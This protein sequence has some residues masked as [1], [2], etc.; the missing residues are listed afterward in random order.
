MRQMIRY[1]KLTL[2]F[3]L[4]LFTITLQ[5]QV[6]FEWTR[7]DDNITV[8][9]NDT[10]QVS[11]T[12][13]FRM[14]SGEIGRGT[15]TWTDP[16]TVEAVFVVMESTP[17]QLQRSSSGNPGTY[18]LFTDGDEQ[19]VR[20]YLPEMV[21]GGDS[22]VVQ[23]NYTLDLATDGLID[24]KV[25]PDEHG[26]PIQSSTLVLNFP[27]GEAPDE[28]LA[29]IVSA[30]GEVISA[31]NNSITLQSTGVIPANQAFQIQ[32]PFGAGI[33]AAAGTSGSTTG[34]TTGDRP[35]APTG[36]TTTPTP[37]PTGGI[38]V[39]LIA[40]I[41]IIGAMVLFGGG[42]K[43]LGGLGGLLGPLLG[44]GSRGGGSRGG[45]GFNFPGFG[46]GRRTPTD[47][48]SIPRSSSPSSSSSSSSSRGFRRGS[49]RNAPNVGGG[50]K[51]DS[52][53]SAGLG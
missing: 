14:I 33:G 28:L 50:K 39:E 24:W 41:C 26:A 22:F 48:R 27:D 17:T 46:S 16:V 19:G 10:I 53:G 12:Q 18:E 44:G 45:G 20:F 8:V 30:N 40:L 23:L 34:S 42:G 13:E 49:S 47:R 35:V 25:I 2:L 9:D 4:L 11:E 43:G 3:T 7:W 51:N 36:P 32:V 52:G 1:S 31:S 5:A 37:S 29:R 38:P 6:E 21:Q 15:R